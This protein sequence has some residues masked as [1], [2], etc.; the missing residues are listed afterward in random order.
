MQ[1]LKRCSL[2]GCDFGFGECYKKERIIELLEKMAVQASHLNMRSD[3]L[4]R[5]RRHVK[6]LESY[7][8]NNNYSKQLD[9][10][11]AGLGVNWKLW[12]SFAKT[13]AFRL[14]IKIFYV[15]FLLLKREKCY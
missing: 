1:E 15:K 6:S 13:S 9:F 14:K 2:T 5:G 4:V 7:A 3:K 11:D 12:H 10:R 8:A